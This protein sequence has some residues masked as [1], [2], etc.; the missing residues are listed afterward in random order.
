MTEKVTWWS[1]DEGD[2]AMQL[3]AI[4][5]HIYERQSWRR[6][7]HD[8]HAKLYA[9]AAIYSMPATYQSSQRLTY[10]PQQQPYNV[11]R[12]I[13][14]TLVAQIAKHR[15][16]PQALTTRGDWKKQKRA[17]KLSQFIEGE[18][19]KSRIFEKWAKLIVRDAATFGHGMLKI[20]ADGKNIVCERAMVRELYVDDWDAQHGDPQNLY[21]I[22]SV[23]RGRLL[24]RFGKKRDGEK[25]SDTEARRRAIENASVAPTSD[26]RVDWTDSTVD[27]VRVVEGWHLPSGPDEEDGRHTIALFGSP[28]TLLDEEWEQETYPFAHLNYSDPLHGYWGQGLVELAEAFQGEIND[29]SEKIS[30]AHWM[31]GGGMIFLPNGSDIVDA[32][33]TNGNVPIIKHQPGRAPTF[34]TPAPIHPAC[35]QRL[36]DLPTDCMNMLG[37]SQMSAQGTKSA[38]EAGMSGI[39]IQTLDDVES[40]RFVVFGRA[41]ESWCL[42]V[43]RRLIDCAKQISAEEGDYEVSVQMK[44]GLLPLSWADVDVEG[45]ELRVFSTSILPSQPA[46]RLDRLN[47]LFNA[48]VIDRATFLRYLDAPDLQAELDMETADR[49]LVD[50]M[51]ELMLDAEE[52]LE[53]AYQPPSPYSTSV[54]WAIRRAQQRLARATIDGAPEENLDLL[55][56][57]I[58]E[59][60]AMK[61]NLGAPPPG[62]GPMPSGAPGPDL[63]AMQP[64]AAPPPGMG[65]A[66][67]NGAPPPPGMM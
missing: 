28:L 56:R 34:E 26:W 19:Y 14:D 60:A 12:S 43:A 36:R 59:S 62:A 10:E 22:R 41:Y 2:R 57:Y 32:S 9:G 66:P 35:Y 29:M 6:D 49:L 53:S 58:A 27:R 25:A 18:F 31:L 37:I 45:Y 39:A 20:Y 67:M 48:G 38:A 3:T 64:T 23:D 15:P 4:A 11:C 63:G 55:R 42:D 8:L 24:A 21:H 61:A 7:A 1:A 46:A 17:R 47:T 65:Q 40:E 33:L 54:D 5:S 13:V 51:I 16:L 52:D 50:E 44:G 30:Q